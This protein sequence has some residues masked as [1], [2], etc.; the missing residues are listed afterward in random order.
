MFPHLNLNVLI[1]LKSSKV[2]AYRVRYREINELYVTTISITFECLLLIDVYST[3]RQCTGLRKGKLLFFRQNRE[4][5]YKFMKTANRGISENRKPLLL[6]GKNRK[7]RG[8][9][10]ETATV[11]VSQTENRTKI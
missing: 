6:R 7:P 4:P 8:K 3:S 11:A 2:E 9:M 1:S 10:P 5:R